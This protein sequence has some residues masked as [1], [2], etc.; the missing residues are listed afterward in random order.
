MS[1]EHGFESPIWLAK[2]VIAHADPRMLRVAVIEV[3][4]HL[5][6]T[7]PNGTSPF[8][9]IDRLVQVTS[10]GKY[11]APKPEPETLFSESFDLVNGRL[12]DEDESVIQDF[13]SNL[14]SIPSSDSNK[15][16]EDFLREHDIPNLDDF[17]EDED[18]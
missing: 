7:A 3:I 14:N 4:E 13:L 12:S 16:Y 17:R 2:A 11:T 6:E 1:V 10:V 5:V 18:E 9:I 15:S 8:E